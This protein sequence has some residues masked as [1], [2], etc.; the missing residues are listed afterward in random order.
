MLTGKTIGQLS[1]LNTSSLD[2]L[3]PVELDGSTYKTSLSDIK[4]TITGDITF[5]GIKIIGAGT[6]SGDGSN[7]STLE[8]VPDNDLYGNNQYLIIDPTT[9][10]HIHIRA[11]GVIDSSS[12]YLYLGGEKS[13]VVVRNLDNSFNEKHWVQINS[14]TGSTQHT[15]IF[16]D[17][18]ILKLNNGLGEIYA[19][20]DSGS[21]RI[22]TAAENVAPNAQIILGGFNEVLKIKSGP[23]LRE[24]TFEG[25]G[26]FTLSGSINGANNLV[27]NDQT[28]SMLSPYLLISQTG[29]LVTNSV[30]LYLLEATTDSITYTLPGSFTEDPCRYSIVSNT[31]NVSSGWFNTSSY[32]FTPQKAGY[33]EITAT[34]DVY[35]NS[36]SAMVIKKNNGIVA[37]AGSFGAVAQQITKIVYLNGSTDF[38]NI[39][40]VGGAANS[41]DQYAERSWFQ[42]RWVGE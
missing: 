17:D 6:G 28:S 1:N 25:N 12:A 8:L 26:D 13:N 9:P 39:F 38:I 11:G 21:V 15:W 3:I 10:N 37:T 2:I 41:R 36:E 20:P 4:N 23:P 33:W 27:T 42:A 34:Y 16:D 35:R 14:Q 19:H 24:W 30:T 31:V 5:E 22:G 32:T 18:G 29:S 40:N 7:Y